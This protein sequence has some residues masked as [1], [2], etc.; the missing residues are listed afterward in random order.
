MI[1][2]KIDKNLIIFLSDIKKTVSNA[3]FRLIKKCCYGGRV[4]N[5]FCKRSLKDRFFVSFSKI[6]ISFSEKKTIVFKNEQRS[7]LLIRFATVFYTIVL[8]NYSFRKKILL[9]IM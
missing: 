1:N 7:F 6:I 3:L 8:K 4:V 5:R 2:S 9:T